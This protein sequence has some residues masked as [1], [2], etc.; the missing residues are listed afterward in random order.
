L[1]LE[2]V[3]D[4]IAVASGKGGVGK[5]TTAGICFWFPS[6][7]FMFFLLSSLGGLE[8]KAFVSFG[9]FKQVFFS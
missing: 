4:V 9:A 8:L 5:S 1:R 3:K 6:F 2:G 7:F